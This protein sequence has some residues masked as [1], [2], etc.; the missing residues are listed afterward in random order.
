MRQAKLGKSR[1]PETRQKISDG[2]KRAA[3]FDKRVRRFEE[4]RCEYPDQED[5]FDKNEEDLLEM[6][7]EVLSENELVQLRKHVE[8][9]RVDPNT[10]F[11]YPSTSIFAMEDL[12]ID[13]LDFKRELFRTLGDLDKTEITR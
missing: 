2:K 5:F 7:E 9:Y 11:E 6:M 1:S 8:T 13:L 3:S 4:L 12:M 10:P